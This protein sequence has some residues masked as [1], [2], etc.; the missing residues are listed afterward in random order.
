MEQLVMGIVTLGIVLIIR[1]KEALV[2]R[3]SPERGTWIA[4]GTGLLAW[5]LSATLLF[6]ARDAVAA[7]LIHYG[8]IYI[9]CGVAIPWGYTLR[10][11]GASVR[12]LGIRRARWKASLIA[13]AVLA[14]LMSLLIVFEA[15]LRA[16]DWTQFTRAL[17]VL[18]GAGGLF[19]LFLYYGF[20][21]LRLEKA[22]GV[23]PAIVLTAL[24]YVTWHTGT[25]LPL[26]PDVPL[27]VIK[28]F[29]VGLMY[30]AVFSA[31]RN[32]LII[33]PL[34]H[35]VGVMIDFTVNL[36]GLAVTSASFPW[37]VASLALMA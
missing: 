18:N 35:A 8:L 10:V 12:E 25:Q 20:I 9:V 31:T 32:L 11:E 26:E 3:W 29:G 23:I 2:V 4:I 30:Q 34:F 27:A 16:I 14:A 21:H 6:F 1:R 13:G 17:V 15:D 7:R 19:E 22:F 28:L 37:A 33:W 24:L 36:D 5:A